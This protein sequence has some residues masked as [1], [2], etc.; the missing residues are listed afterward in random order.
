MNRLAG[1]AA[2][3]LALGSAAAAAKAP[4]RPAGP[5]RFDCNLAMLIQPQGQVSDFTPVTISFVV[6]K[7]VVRN[8]HVVDKGGILYPGGN[9]RFVRKPDVISMEAVDMPAERPG[10]WTGSVEKKMYKFTLSIGPLAQAVT[11]GLGRAPVKSSGRHGLIWNASN[12]PEGSP[13]PI[14]GSGL[15]NCAPSQAQGNSK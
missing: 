1:L 10:R 12:Q 7:D 15:G 14:S 4:A 11:M 2:A 9:F 13:R 8:I 6:D 3:S 5:F